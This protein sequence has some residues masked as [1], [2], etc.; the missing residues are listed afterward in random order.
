MSKQVVVI[1]REKW[2]HGE[3]SLESCLLRSSDG[4]M[5]CLGFASLACGLDQEQ[6]RGRQSV[7]GLRRCDVAVP[8]TLSW[9]NGEVG[10]TNSPD[11][12]KLMSVNDCILGGE[13]AEV[14]GIRSEAAREAYIAKK[15]G[16]HGIE[17]QFV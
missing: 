10:A 6:I 17:V 2:L 5:C 3:G 8:E 15:M 12:Y 11:A 16:E 14:Y 1:E 4:K 7:G 13:M 9:L